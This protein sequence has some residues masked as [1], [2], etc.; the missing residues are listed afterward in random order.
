MGS[1]GVPGSCVTC[2]QVGSEGPQAATQAR[3]R[4][5]KGIGEMAQTRLPSAM[6][7][8]SVLRTTRE[9]EGRERGGLACKIQGVRR[10][11]CTIMHD[12]RQKSLLLDRQLRIDATPF[13]SI[14]F[15][16]EGKV[17]DETYKQD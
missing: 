5:R 6:T 1:D 11:W 14:T 4:H 10:I 3:A 17:H 8:A 16:I 12:D 2:A 13:I 9:R 7:S 15:E